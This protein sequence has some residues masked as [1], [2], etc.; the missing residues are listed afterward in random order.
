MKLSKV[1]KVEDMNREVEV[2]SELISNKELKERIQENV[3]ERLREKEQQNKEKRG[4]LR[5]E[6][7]K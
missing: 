2:H 4:V 7:E 6:E 5:I 3:R 1:K